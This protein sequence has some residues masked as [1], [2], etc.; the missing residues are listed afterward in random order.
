MKQ[1]IQKAREILADTAKALATE[2]IEE[3]TKNLSDLTN[4]IESIHKWAETAEETISTQKAALE[5]LEKSESEETNEKKSEETNKSSASLSVYDDNLPK[6]IQSLI[7]AVNGQKES[8]GSLEKSIQDALK[9]N[10][11][12]QDN[13]EETK[14]SASPLDE[15][16]SRL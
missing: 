5:K 4:E 7:D 14:K 8:V 15:L 1:N 3:V 6:L 9:P 2:N 12:K 10:T 16:A 13:S 11:S